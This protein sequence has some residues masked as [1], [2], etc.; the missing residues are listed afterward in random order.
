ML[1]A[2]K[3]T[4]RSHLYTE[5]SLEACNM[6]K[7]LIEAATLVMTRIFLRPCPSRTPCVVVQRVWQPPASDELP[8]VTDS[9]VPTWLIWS[10]AERATDDRSAASF[11][12]L[13]LPQQPGITAS[14]CNVIE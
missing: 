6:D 3:T 7:P 11:G 9:T 10:S 13:N 4:I 1:A 14:R 8:A 5:T 12:L 2:E